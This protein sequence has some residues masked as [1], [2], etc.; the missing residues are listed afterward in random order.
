MCR[1][2]DVVLL[3]IFSSPFLSLV[4]HLGDLRGQATH[5]GGGP[6]SFAGLSENGRH[7]GSWTSGS[8][9]IF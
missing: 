9:L 1:V 4:N 8:K 7:G 5:G 3:S 6:A 2:G